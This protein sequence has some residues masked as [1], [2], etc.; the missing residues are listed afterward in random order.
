MER[1]FE[2]CTSIKEAPY[3][4]EMVENMS[5]TFYGCTNLEK[6]STIP[7]SVTN[8]AG[9]YRDCPNLSGTLE[10]NANVTGKDLGPDTGN[11]TDYHSFLWGSVS[12]GKTLHLTGECVVLEQLKQTANNP[13]ITL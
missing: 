5:F 2:R 1:T 6:G 10:V 3:I 8:I 11:I 12:N 4:P 9:A 7:K 13:N